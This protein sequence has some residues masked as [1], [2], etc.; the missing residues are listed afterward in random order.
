MPPDVACQ[1][2]PS[3][4]NV[5]PGWLIAMMEKMESSKA[6]AVLGPVQALYGTDCPAWI[7]KGDFHSNRPV[8]N[9]KKTFTGCST[10][11][12]LLR[13]TSPAVQN[14]RFRHELGKTGGEDTLFFT[15]IHKAGGKIDYA[16]DALIT[17]IAPKSRTNFMWLFKRRFRSGQTHGVLL[18]ESNTDG[19]YG[20][21]RNILLATAKIAYCDIAALMNIARHDRMRYWLLRGALH[22]G[23]VLRLFGK[24][25]IVQYGEQEKPP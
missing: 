4:I 23:V 16:P 13:R 20:H 11:N 2:A 15:A 9:E 25:E 17:E 7:S 6:D 1:L 14:L 8:M 3:A 24:A 21:I 10:G 18:L 5:T 22:A 19:L 12:A